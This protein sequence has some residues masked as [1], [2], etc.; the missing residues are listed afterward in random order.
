MTGCPNGCARPYMAELGFVGSATE[1]YQIWLGGSPA[2]TRLAQAYVDRLHV[3]DIETGLEP[4]FVYFKQSRQPGERFGD[5]C[6][7]VGMEAIREFT[8][9]YQ[10]EP[11]DPQSDT[12]LI[13][14]IVMPE[15]SAAQIGGKARHRISV[16]P[17]LYTR[18]K[19]AAAR[20]G[21]PMAQITA[22]ALEAYLNTL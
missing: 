16:K 13:N 18:L 9:T 4:I 8:V 11:L 2:Q 20:H 17:Q 10:S 19:E 1:S 15:S 7:R 21:K 12:G 14:E 6:D 3:N 22:E 5:F